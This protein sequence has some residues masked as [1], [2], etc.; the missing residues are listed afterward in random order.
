MA[1]VKDLKPFGQPLFSDNTVKRGN[2]YIYK[3]RAIA[4]P[5]FEATKGE[6][7]LGPYDV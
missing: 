3:I 5:G 4:A 6:L 7:K 2:C 1:T